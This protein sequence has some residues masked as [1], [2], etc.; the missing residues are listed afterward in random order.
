MMTTQATHEVLVTADELA[1]MGDI[2]R[3]ELIDGRIVPRP[4]TGDEHGGIEGNIFAA[5]KAY[6]DTTIPNCAGVILSPGIRIAPSG[7]ST[8]KS[9][10]T[11][12]CNAVRTTIMNFSYRL[13]DAAAIGCV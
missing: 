4:P 7:E 11:V 9:R 6:A 2:G 1:R 8:M 12:N 3:C 13:K 5:L 10:I